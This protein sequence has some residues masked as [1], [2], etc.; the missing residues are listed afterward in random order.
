MICN[1]TIEAIDSIGVNDG[2]GVEE[3]INDGRKVENVK[4]VEKI[5]KS[6]S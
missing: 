5:G 2:G 6:G 1:A 3:G 4:A